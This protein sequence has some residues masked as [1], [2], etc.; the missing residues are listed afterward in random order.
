MSPTLTLR[1]LGVKNS[2]AWILEKSSSVLFPRRKSSFSIPKHG[3]PKGPLGPYLDTH[4]N[5][6]SQKNNMKL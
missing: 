1:F 4:T 3:Q 6:L 2:L 5:Q